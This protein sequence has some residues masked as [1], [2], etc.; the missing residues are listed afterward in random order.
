MYELE[1]ISFEQAEDLSMRTD[2]AIEVNEPECNEINTADAAAFY[3]EGYNAAIE[4]ANVRLSELKDKIKNTI[5]EIENQMRAHLVESQVRKIC[6][7]LQR[8]F[9]P[10]YVS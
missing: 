7:I 3:Y 2:Y 10:G 4:K 6:S 1:L 5:S 8:N 9:E